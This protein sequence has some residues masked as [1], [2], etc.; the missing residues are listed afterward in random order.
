[1]ATP[2]EKGDLLEAA[3]AA[4]ERHILAFSPA[5]REE[6]FA[7]E[8]KKIIKVGDVHHEIDIFVTIDAGHE[9][10]SIFIFECKNWLDAIGKNDVIIFSHKIDA[11]R[12][13]HG[14][15]VAK[16]FTKDAQAQAA[17]DSRLTLLVA[18]EHD[19]TTMPRPIDLNFHISMP[20]LE[21]FEVNLHRRGA[22][23][24]KQGVVA[25][26]T[27]QARL[28]GN[29]INL[30]HY[31]LGWAE[32]LCAA[33]VVG[34]RTEKLD[35]GDY[36]RTANAERRFGLGELSVNNLDIERGEISLRYKVRVLRPLVVSYFEVVSRGH[37]RLLAPV[38]LPTGEKI[39]FSVTTAQG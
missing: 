19:P 13:T 33:D 3:V 16:S 30:G 5:L 28:L 4:I 23:G 17:Q 31:L 20:T 11:V 2:R 6:T 22:T 25:V 12:A 39:Q 18:S 14:F 7:I 35:D 29:D 38:Q 10:K 15:L 8:S 36:E 26:E 24:R 34:F 32:E 9:Y 37:F 1:M 21:H 27:A